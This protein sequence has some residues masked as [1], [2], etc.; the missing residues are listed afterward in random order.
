MD[1][2]FRGCS[3]VIFDF[4]NCKVCVCG[5]SEGWIC[6]IYVDYYED[7]VGDVVSKKFVDGE[8]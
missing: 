2:C 4:F 7:W 5:D 3:S 8:I 6:G 1:E